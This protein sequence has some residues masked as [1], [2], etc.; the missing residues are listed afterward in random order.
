MLINLLF[1]NLLLTFF[2][3]YTKKYILTLANPFSA[4]QKPKNTSTNFS[5]FKHFIIPRALCELQTF[6]PPVII[7]A[8]ANKHAGFGR[9]ATF[10]LFRFDL[11]LSSLIGGD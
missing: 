8:I 11:G 7:A 1:T 5:N 6:S 4:T 9:L 3:S 10:R 2:L